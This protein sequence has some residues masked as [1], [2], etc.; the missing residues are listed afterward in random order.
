MRNLHRGDTRG[1]LLRRVGPACYVC[2]TVDRKTPVKIPY[3]RYS[4][5]TNGVWI[6][7]SC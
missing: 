4:V 7:V 2:T 3:I 6:A 1:E 5:S